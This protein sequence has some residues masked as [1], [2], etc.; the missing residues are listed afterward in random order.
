VR[1][2]VKTNVNG[3]SHYPGVGDPPA[4]VGGQLPPAGGLRA[5]QV[6][7]R[8]AASFCTP[9]TFNLTNGLAVTWAP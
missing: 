1:L 4:P 3:S 9:D 8:N 6:W 5:Y 2:G 7:Y